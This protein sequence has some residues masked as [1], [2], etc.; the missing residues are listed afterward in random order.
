MASQGLILQSHHTGGILIGESVAYDGLENFSY[1][2]YDPN[3][4]NHVV[5]RESLFVYDFNFAA[6]NRKGR[7][8]PRQ[9]LRKREI[10][11]KHGPYPSRAIHKA[12]ER[13]FRR[14]LER[15]DGEL[16]L[17]TDNHFAYRE[18]IA[19]LH[20]KERITHLITP[21]KV[22]R[23]YRNRLFAVNHLDMLTRHQ[24]AA[25]KR[26]TIAFSKHSIAMIESFSLLMV[27]K[28]F[29]RS[30]FYKK[31]V[32]DER[33]DKESPAMRVGAAGKILSFSEFY[34]LRMTKHQV[35][36]NEDWK[37]FIERIDPHSRRK[38]SPRHAS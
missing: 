20:D 23:N 14:L 2:Q 28:N 21:S 7:M 17:H 8:S 11:K 10:E 37:N 5:G 38:I 4:I 1:S 3:N 24:S 13:I 36:L 32:S 29:M 12:T 18:V 25:F 33:A 31:H 9:R 22:A 26:E 34:S 30:V 6:F 35:T 27:H 15:S 19:H 16:K